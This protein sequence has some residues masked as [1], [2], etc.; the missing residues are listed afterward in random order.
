M[1]FIKKSLLTAAV[2]ATTV[3][4]HAGLSTTVGFVSDYYFRGANLGDAGAYASLDYEQSGFF[5]GT[6]WIDDSTGGG[7]NSGGDGL[8]TDFYVGYGWENDDFSAGIAYNRY[9]Y[10]CRGCDNNESEIALSAG[11]GGFGLEYVFG[12]IDAGAGSSDQDYDV[13]TLSW[14]G[15]VVGVTLAQVSKDD[16]DGTTSGEAEYSYA[17]FSAS[18]EISG[19]SVSAI[20]GVTFDEESNGADVPSGD[21]YMLIDISKSFDL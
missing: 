13:I 2:A 12:V 1:S 21:G 3:S 5:V 17:E 7:A 15:E 6:W 16:V 9:E 10:T 18:K 19:L 8:E 20:L 14:S 11:F 4:A